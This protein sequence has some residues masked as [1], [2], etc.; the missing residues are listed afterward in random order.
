MDKTCLKKYAE[1]L[2]SLGVN[3]QKG[4]SLVISYTLEGL[5]LAK[6]AAE[7]AYDKGARRVDFIFENDELKHMKYC[8]ESE[9]TLLDIPLWQK[10]QKDAIVD[11][12]SCYIAILAEN[13]E[14]FFDINPLLLSKISVARHN[15]F[16]KYFDAATTNAI[17]WCLCAVPCDAWAQ[18]MFPSLSLDEAISKQWQYI[19]KTM[20]LD[21][22]DSIA[23][24]NEHID[25][26]QKISDY[27]T[28][29]EF[30]T[31][32]YSNSL[33]TDFTIGLPRGYYFSGGN[34][35]SRDGVRFTAN[36]PTEEVF[37]LPDRNTAN[38]TVVASMPLIHTGAVIDRFF[39]EFKNGKIVDYGAE[40]GHEIL[41]GIIE[42]DEGS[43]YL[44]EIALVPFNSPIN[45]LNTLFYNTL[46]DENAS[47]HLAIGE[48][49]PMI[50]NIDSLSESEQ[51]NLGVNKSCVHVDFMIGTAD[52]QI[53][54]RKKD[55]AEVQIF[56]N[57]NFVEFA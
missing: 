26:L 54:A 53:T 56:K 34:E 8:H 14:A 10:M 32:T 6:A 45:N 15:A 48:A 57:G 5:E 47:C 13:P 43:H 35:I 38:G 2:I 25:R 28:S 42:S 46:F 19:A 23:A 49:Y 52:L 9:S 31:L 12:K 11:N 16:K 41:Q 40:V 30:T 29:Q 27:L 7:C 37:T 24:W 4:D 55:G 50:K 3:L 1:L 18:K 20:R 44:G 21:A 33:G 22:L 17:R 51:A 36:M 39:L